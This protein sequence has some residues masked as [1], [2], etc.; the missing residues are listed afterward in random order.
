M[1]HK[2]TV[3]VTYHLHGNIIIFTQVKAQID[4]HTA[5]RNGKTNLQIIFNYVKV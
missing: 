4:E 2:F 5:E 3:P 1:R